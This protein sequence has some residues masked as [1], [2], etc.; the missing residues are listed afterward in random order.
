MLP[1][2][3]PRAKLA[4]SAPNQRERHSQ[5]GYLNKPSNVHEI[6][7]LVAAEAIALVRS[8]FLT[9]HRCT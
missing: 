3:L 9:R 2:K 6:T 1:T 4:Q 8:D 5:S 7:K